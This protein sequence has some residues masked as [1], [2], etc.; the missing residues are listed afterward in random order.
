MEW[1]VGKILSYDVGCWKNKEPTR[2][3]SDSTVR[4]ST[5]ESTRTFTIMRISQSFSLRSGE[6]G[7]AIEISQN[8]VPTGCVIERKIVSSGV[9][10]AASF[11]GHFG[12]VSD[13]SRTDF[14]TSAVHGGL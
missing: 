9:P 4:V 10:C 5:F 7:S 14:D 1:D 11:F 3:R 12:S 8:D 2:S 13:E 6:A